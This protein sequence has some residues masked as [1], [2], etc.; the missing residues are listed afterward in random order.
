MSKLKPVLVHFA[1][2]AAN[3]AWN[4]ICK[5]AADS[6]QEHKDEMFTTDDRDEAEKLRLK[7]KYETE[8]WKDIEFYVRK[9][10]KMTK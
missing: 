3:P 7:V 10:S 2:L 9:N 8:F 4:L 6:I 5:Q 1:Q